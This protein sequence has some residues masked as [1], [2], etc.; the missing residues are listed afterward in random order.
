MSS[1]DDNYR[2]MQDAKEMQQVKTEY[3]LLKTKYVILETAVQ[4]HRK[5]IGVAYGI[6]SFKSQHAANM[7]LWA[8]VEKESLLSTVAKK[9][10]TATGIARPAMM[11]E[12]E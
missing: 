12:T 3:E 9:I 11:E 2:L 4:N 7:K 5:Q 1:I 6:G 10:K 8:H